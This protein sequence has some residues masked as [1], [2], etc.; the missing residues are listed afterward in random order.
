MRLRS[1]FKMFIR[2]LNTAI[3]EQMGYVIFSFFCVLAPEGMNEFNI[4]SLSS[5]V[6]FEIL[7]KNLFEGL[8]KK[9]TRNLRYK[10]MWS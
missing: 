1:V 9:K 6:W 7:H 4:L 2:I 3:T 10:K 5:C 8:K